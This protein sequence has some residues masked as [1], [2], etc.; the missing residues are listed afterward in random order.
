MFFYENK[1][2]NRTFIETEQ[3]QKNWRELGYGEDDLYL[4]QSAIAV[5][6]NKGKL[7]KGSGGIRKIRFALTNSG[8]RPGV[9]VC[10]LD[11]RKTKIC[12]LITVYSK[13]VK[14]DLSKEEIR[15]LKKYVMILKRHY[16][17]SDKDE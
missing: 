4:L 7:I 6:P 11:F 16:G 10:Y 2:I 3:F 8:K 12:I 14:D 17:G 15:L 1:L 9:R 5:D 13:K